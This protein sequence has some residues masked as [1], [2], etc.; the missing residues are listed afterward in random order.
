VARI[1]PSTQIQSTPQ[2][3]PSEPAP[4]EGLF[5]LFILRESGCPFFYRIYTNREK[6]PDP[7][8]L[9]GFFIALS[10][11]AKEVTNGQIETVTTEPCRYTFHPLNGGLLVICSSKN[12]NPILLEKI[13]T[14]ISQL[15]VTKYSGR[16]VKPQPAAIIAPNLG[17]Q[18]DRI[19][20]QTT[21]CMSQESI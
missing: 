15:F 16:L 21:T 10:L 14:L 8:I 20:G 4:P 1:P 5:S 11:F 7:A 18:I 9:S 12:F 6:H 13:A 3:E 17:K 2:N 19:F